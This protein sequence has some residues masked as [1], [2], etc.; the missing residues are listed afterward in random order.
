MRV[1]A[2]PKQPAKYQKRNKF[3]EINEDCI[4]CLVLENP[5]MIEPPACNF[6]NKEVVSSDAHE[7]LAACSSCRT[8]QYDEIRPNT[9]ELAVWSGRSFFLYS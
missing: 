5:G 9:N 6:R 2:E 1:V 8:I 4:H 3:W 7:K